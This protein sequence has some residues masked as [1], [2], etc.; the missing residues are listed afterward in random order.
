MKAASAF[1]QACCKLRYK[2][3]FFASPFCEPYDGKKRRETCA[4]G[5]G[6]SGASGAHPFRR[7]T[8]I[9]AMRKTIQGTTAFLGSNCAPRIALK[10][11]ILPLGLS[12]AYEVCE[13]NL[14]GNAAAASIP[15]I[16]TA[17]LTPTPAPPGG[18]VCTSPVHGE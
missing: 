9:R 3:F 15:A 6:A 18:G 4:E 11:T 1:S 13:I 17:R 14:E 2:E 5:A 10:Q 12:D 16:L 8:Q 7:R